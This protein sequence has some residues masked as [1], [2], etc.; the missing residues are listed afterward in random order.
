MFLNIK[1]NIVLLDSERSIES[2]GLTMIFRLTC[3]CE[4]WFKKL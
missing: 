2:I 3:I 4:S 1:I